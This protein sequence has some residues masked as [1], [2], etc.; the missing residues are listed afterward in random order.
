MIVYMQMIEDPAEQGKFENI[1]RTYRND[2]YKATMRILNN[3]QDAEDAVHNAFVKIAENI[4]KIDKAVCTKTRNYVITI[5]ENKAIDLYRKKQIHPKLEYT[6]EIIGIQV[7]YEDAGDLTACILKL[8]ARQRSAIILRYGYGY[9]LKEIA[10]I[11]GVTYANA[12][13][14]EQRAKAGLKSICEEAGIEW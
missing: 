13:K 12:M 1:Y 7:E 14:I 4:G 9:S 5:A 6:D 11:L 2:M 10:S 3:V 8:P